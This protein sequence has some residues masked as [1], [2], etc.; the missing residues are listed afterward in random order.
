[1]ER[2]MAEVKEKSALV[3]SVWW[4]WFGKPFLFAWILISSNSN[5]LRWSCVERVDADKPCKNCCKFHVYCQIYHIYSDSYKQ[6]WY[7]AWWDFPLLIRSIWHIFPL[8]WFCTMRWMRLLQLNTFDCVF[9]FSILS[10]Y[11]YVSALD[12]YISQL[13]FLRDWFYGTVQTGCMLALC[14][15]SRVKRLEQKSIH[16]SPRLFWLSHQNMEVLLS[17]RCWNRFSRIYE[18]QFPDSLCSF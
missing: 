12:F 13:S 15:T 16:H 8:R 1:M 14:P 4:R 7:P 5:M 10:L 3:L 17:P 2:F 11:L 6:M 18:V 9:S